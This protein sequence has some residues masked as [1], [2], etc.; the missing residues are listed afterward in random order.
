V[1]ESC[2]GQPP[3]AV[4]TLVLEQV[5]FKGFATDDFAATGSSKP[6]GSRLAA[7]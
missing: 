2:F 6:L 5:A 1:D 4:G 3:L 7:F